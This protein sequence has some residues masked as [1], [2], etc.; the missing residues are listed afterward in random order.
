[1]ATCRRIFTEILESWQ[2]HA[3]AVASGPAAL[4]AIRAWRES[5]RA[6]D[7]V[8]LDPTL[9]GTDGLSLAEQIKRDSRPAGVPVLVLTSAGRRGVGSGCRKSGVEGYLTKPVMASELQAAIQ[10]VLSDDG[11]PPE[12]RP[13]VTRHTL[14][15]ARTRLK[16]LLAEDTLVIRSLAV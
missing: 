7:L 15:E 1:N 10:V 9:P 11:R 14:R 2:M 16:I 12:S 4:S 13:L 8:L 3:L 6:F 5:G